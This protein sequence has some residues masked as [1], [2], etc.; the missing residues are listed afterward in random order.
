MKKF[1]SLVLGISLSFS[2]F[3][4]VFAGNGDVFSVGYNMKIWN[5]NIDTTR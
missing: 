3:T 1:I 4:V 5:D 2:T